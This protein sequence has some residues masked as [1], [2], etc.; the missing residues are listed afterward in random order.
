MFGVRGWIEKTVKVE[1]PVPLELV[2]TQEVASWFSGLSAAD[3]SRCRQQGL[4]DTSVDGIVWLGDEPLRC[5]VILDPED[6][7]SGSELPKKLPVQAYQVVPETA[8]HWFPHL[9]WSWTMGCYEFRQY[10]TQPLDPMPRLCPFPRR[11]D[12]MCREVQAALNVR[13]M[14]NTPAEYC[15]PED[16][17]KMITNWFTLQ[18]GTCEVTVGGRLLPDFP[19]IHAVGRSSSRPPCLID[20]RWGNRGPKVTLV[21]K[22]VTFDTG[23]LDLKSAAGMLHM[24]KDMGGAAHAFALAQWLMGEQFPLQIRLLIPAAD[25]AVSGDSYRPGDI[26][27][28]R[29]GLSVEITNT[30][31]EGRLLLA[32]ALTLALEEEPELV[33]DFATLTGAARVAL[34]PSL[35]ALFANRDATVKEAL[36]CAEARK[37]PVW[38]MPLH[39][40]YASDL[41]GSLSD[42]VNAP[43]K[44]YGGAIH[45]ALFLQAFVGKEADWIHLDVMSANLDAKPG[46]P[47]GGEAMG[48]RAMYELITRRFHLV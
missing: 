21:G 32:D 35:P 19:L 9:L 5:V 38:H 27:Y 16:M 1:N 22:G 17:G 23:G 42:L 40:P 34:G 44:P 39:Q 3:Q 6:R 41:K 30:D 28:S 24:K 31:A 4:T 20:A 13:E 33:I 15:G 7:W 14:V 45:A 26:F 43:L 10:R 8:E 29:S 25:N 47:K 48:L 12:S 2:A 18:G 46:R 37:D 36:A 11:W